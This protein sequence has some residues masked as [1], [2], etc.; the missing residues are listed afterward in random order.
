MPP[1]VK[2]SPKAI[3][4]VLQ[5][6]PSVARSLQEK[7]GLT[8]GLIKCG[9]VLKDLTGPNGPDDSDQMGIGP[10]GFPTK[11]PSVESRTRPAREFREID[12][13]PDTE[14]LWSEWDDFARDVKVLPTHSTY[15]EEKA[16]GRGENKA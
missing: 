8:V 14:R 6:V 15:A 11:S 10:H 7:W 13:G 5:R 12:L 2:A 9:Q 1:K 16:L 3:A 4:F